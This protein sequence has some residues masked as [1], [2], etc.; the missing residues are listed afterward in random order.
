[1]ENNVE[2]EKGDGDDK[3]RKNEIIFNNRMK[4]KEE[5]VDNHICDGGGGDDKV[6][7][8]DT[9]VMMKMKPMVVM[10]TTKNENY[11]KYRKPKVHINNNIRKIKTPVHLPHTTYT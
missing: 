2:E 9:R 8:R 10:I 4:I 5:N 7:S 3:M 11:K 1:M 6:K